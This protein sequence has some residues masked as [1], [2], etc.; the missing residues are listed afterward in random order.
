M[1]GATAQAVAPPICGPQSA[2]PSR[3]MGSPRLMAISRRHRATRRR[4][5][6]SVSGGFGGSGGGRGRSVLGTTVSM[7]GER[8]SHETRALPR[9]NPGG[10]RLSALV[11]AGCRV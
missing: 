10:S 4:I 5:S 11:M 9:S 7:H 3:G 8:W 2:D 6:A 1:G